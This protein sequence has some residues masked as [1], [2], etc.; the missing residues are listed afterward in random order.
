MPSL[1][2]PEIFVANN[3]TNENWATSTSAPIM[4]AA[5]YLQDPD[6]FKTLVPEL[7]RYFLA[8][9]WKMK[10]L[11]PQKGLRDGLRGAEKW[12]NGEITDEK[13]WKLEWI[14]E[15]EAFAFENVESP[16]EIDKLKALI[17]T[18]DILKDVECD[19]AHQILKEAA[20]FTD[21]AIIYPK[22]TSAPYVESLCT[23][24]FLCSELLRKHIQPHFHGAPYKGPIDII[25]KV[26]PLR[27]ASGKIKGPLSKF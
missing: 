15:A 6:H 26:G 18:V 13:F 19:I 25:S 8:C 16:E 17:A 24:R 11:I 21:R 27:T 12:I 20:Y 10:H 9:C 4:L 7:H 22:I 23:S 14:A 2:I 3:M 5:L 1:K